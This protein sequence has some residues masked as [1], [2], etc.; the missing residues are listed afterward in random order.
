MRP[1]IIVEKPCLPDRVLQIGELLR[2]D[3]RWQH[4]LSQHVRDPCIALFKDSGN[5]QSRQLHNL[6]RPSKIVGREFAETD[7][8]NRIELY[9]PSDA[10]FSATSCKV[11]C[12]SKNRS[13]VTG[14]ISRRR[15]LSPSNVAVGQQHKYTQ[16]FSHQK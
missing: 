10:F 12:S 5:I 6:Q 11:Q 4:S 8:E 2:Q 7:E 9:L 1:F 15:Q 3:T 14:K 16:A 13:T